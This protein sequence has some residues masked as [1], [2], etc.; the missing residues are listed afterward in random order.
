MVPLQSSYTTSGKEEKNLTGEKK[1]DK[2]TSSPDLTD[3][4]GR[5]QKSIEERA[6]KTD[7]NIDG[8]T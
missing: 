4:G 3:E 5:P 1:S 7:S 2:Q 8:R 6:D